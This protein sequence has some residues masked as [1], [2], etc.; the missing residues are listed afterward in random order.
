M[1]GC[2][3]SA[4]GKSFTFVK[5]SPTKLILTSLKLYFKSV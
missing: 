4:V 1:I 2:A 3:Q 5:C